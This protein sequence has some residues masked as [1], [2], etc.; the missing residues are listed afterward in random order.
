MVLL[1]YDFKDRMMKYREGE[2]NFL[3]DRTDFTDVPGFMGT[4]IANSLVSFLILII[5]F[6]IIFTILFHPLFW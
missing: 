3:V 4:V 1:L 6:G 2:V 5:S